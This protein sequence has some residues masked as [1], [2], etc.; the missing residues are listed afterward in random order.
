MILGL[1]L[2]L[3]PIHLLTLNLLT[4]GAPALALGVE[5][6]EPDIMR[7]PPRPASEGILNTEMRWLIAVQG[8]A[9]AGASLAAFVIALNQF[10]DDLLMAQTVAFAT[11]VCGEI[12][13]AYSARSERWALWSIGIFSNRFMILASTASIAILLL[14]MYVPILQPIFDTRPLPLEGWYIVAPLSLVSIVAA[15]LGKAV[16]RRRARAPE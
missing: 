8:I 11:V 3:R 6:G 4:D 9:L 5:K 1:P 14:T 7:R 12:L 2:P 16:L 15:E 10:P 13:R